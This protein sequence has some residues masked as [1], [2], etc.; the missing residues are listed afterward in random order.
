MVDKAPLTEEEKRE[1]Y[2]TGQYVFKAPPVC[3]A[4]WNDKSWIDWIDS[5][6]G[7]RPREPRRM[8]RA[9]DFGSDEDKEA[10]GMT[11]N[12]KGEWIWA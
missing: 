1:L 2:H 4:Y 8:V 6:E 12:T 7:W 3:T 9:A 11:K 5:C 10:M